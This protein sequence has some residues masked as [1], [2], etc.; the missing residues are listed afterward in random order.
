MH[1][2]GPSGAETVCSS[3]LGFPISDR[4]IDI[5][6]QATGWKEISFLSVSWHEQDRSWRRWLEKGALYWKTVDTAMLPGRTRLYGSP[7]FSLAPNLRTFSFHGYGC[8]RSLAHYA[9]S[10]TAF[11]FNRIHSLNINSPTGGEAIVRDNIHTIRHALLH[12]PHIRNLTVSLPSPYD[13]YEMPTMLSL[14]FLTSLTL[15]VDCGNQ[16]MVKDF[17]SNIA[18]P[19]LH[20]L[21]LK[22]VNN[23]ARYPFLEEYVNTVLQLCSLSSFVHVGESSHSSISS[24]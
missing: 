8:C 18:L 13:V 19:R 23:I 9:S 10:Q 14:S 21:G 24:D 4:Q 1:W 17:L 12:F 15:C 5:L 2:Q 3:H 11:P 20:S 7:A 22:Y 16:G 6:C